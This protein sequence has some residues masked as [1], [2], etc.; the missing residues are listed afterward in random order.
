MEWGLR[1]TPQWDWEYS[2]SQIGG[3][4]DWHLFV[5]SLWEGLIKETMA[6][7]STSDLALMP[8]SLV[9]L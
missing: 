4:L 5:G 8:D 2:V 9:P 7:V 6:S 3:D 1:E